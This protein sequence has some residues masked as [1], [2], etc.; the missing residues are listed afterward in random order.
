MDRTKKNAVL[1]LV[2]ALSVYG[3]AQLMR[4]TLY[5]EHIN[6]YRLPENVGPWKG[7]D[8]HADIDFLKSALGAQ[9]IVFRS[10]RKGTREI[11]LYA[12]YY[13]DV[14]SADQVHAPTV[15]YPGQGWTI[16]RDDTVTWKMGKGEVE[17]DRIMVRKGSRQLLI[18]NWWQTGEKVIPRNSINRFYLILR[19]VTGR[20]PSTA[21]IRLSLDAGR[22]LEDDEKAV[23]QF[24][25]NLMPL[26]RNYFP[27]P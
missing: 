8:I 24:C 6:V 17:V 20:N 25:S 21:W 19:S 2:L 14:D 26:L 3:S 9:S 4:R 15:C 16:A 18:Y 23:A 11:T 13:K 7:T 27:E 10:Y 22:S 1:V 5:S 12:A